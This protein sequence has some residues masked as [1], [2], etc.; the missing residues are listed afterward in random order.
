MQ[1]NVTSLCQDY[2]CVSQNII[3]LNFD[4][5]KTVQ[6]QQNAHGNLGQQ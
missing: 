2:D 3:L 5:L 4:S 6:A 1:N